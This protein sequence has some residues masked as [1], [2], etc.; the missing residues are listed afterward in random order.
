MK[1]ERN[2]FYIFKVQTWPQEPRK[3]QEEGGKREALQSK[4][5][6]IKQIIQSKLKSMKPE[7]GWP[8]FL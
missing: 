8:I 5:A 6:Q 7:G 3:H 4:R 2:N 1:K